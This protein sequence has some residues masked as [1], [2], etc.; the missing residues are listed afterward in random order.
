MMFH[1]AVP[2][3]LINLAV[4][5][6]ATKKNQVDEQRGTPPPVHSDGAGEDDLGA[7]RRI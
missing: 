7:R 6:G 5:A 3:S 1:G 2:N 4:A